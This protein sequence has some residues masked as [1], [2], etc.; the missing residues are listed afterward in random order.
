MNQHSC[1]MMTS[2]IVCTQ[3]LSLIFDL[4]PLCA[5]LVQLL[6]AWL[7]AKFEAGQRLMVLQTYELIFVQILRYPSIPLCTQVAL[8]AHNHS[9]LYCQFLTTTLREKWWRHPSTKPCKVLLWPFLRAQ[10]FLS[11]A[12]FEVLGGCRVIRAYL[13]CIKDTEALAEP[14]QFTTV[15]LDTSNTILCLIGNTL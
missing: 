2:M 13:R 4:S 12:H 9:G 15:S 7:T 1:F 3:L 5:E 8:W 6:W 11:S 14:S 10:R